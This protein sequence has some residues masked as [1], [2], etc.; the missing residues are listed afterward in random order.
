MNKKVVKTEKGFYVEKDDHVNK[1]H[2]EARTEL[3]LNEVANEVIGRSISC[4][5][6]TF[7]ALK[8]PEAAIEK[9]SGL[10]GTS[11]VRVNE[12]IAHNKGQLNYYQNWITNER[13]KIKHAE[14]SLLKHTENIINQVQ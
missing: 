2:P 1:L 10:G 12:M 14:S 7:E 9:K 4:P 8:S 5:K 13:K 3:E 11:K 6:H